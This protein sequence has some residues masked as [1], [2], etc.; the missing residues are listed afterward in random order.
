MSTTRYY[1]A[2]CGSIYR[3]TET[4]ARPATKDT[5]ARPASTMQARRSTYA[6][7]FSPEY[8][9][10][11]DEVDRMVSVGSFIEV[12]CPSSQKT[13]AATPATGPS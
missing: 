3:V 12:P 9:T 1:L 4:P 8:P 10:T 7:D 11:T 13:E 6:T 5:R 2:R